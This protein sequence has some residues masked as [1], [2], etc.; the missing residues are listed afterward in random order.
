MKNFFSTQPKVSVRRNFLIHEFYSRK[1]YLFFLSALPISGFH[2]HTYSTGRTVHAVSSCQF[3]SSLEKILNIEFCLLKLLIFWQ[4][5]SLKIKSRLNFSTFWVCKPVIR[6]YLSKVKL[7][8]QKKNVFA[9]MVISV[10]DFHSCWWK[11][12]QTFAKKRTGSNEILILFEAIP[13]P[14]KIGLSI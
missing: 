7:F 3:L 8:H 5:L 6:Y 12:Y 2:S 4:T 9:P 1:I 13:K 11:S 10:V 14:T